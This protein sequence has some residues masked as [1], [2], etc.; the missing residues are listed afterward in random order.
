MAIE[1]LGDIADV[2]VSKAVSPS[3]KTW[4]T[5][6]DW[7]SAVSESGVAHEA[8]PNTAHSDASTVQMGYSY[9]NPPAAADLELLLPLD[10]SAGSTAY[11]ASGNNRDGDITG[12]NVVGQSGDLGTGGHDYSFGEVTLTGEGSALSGYSELTVAALINPD[13][14]PNGNFQ[15]IVAHD[16]ASTNNDQAYQLLVD[17]GTANVGW[18]VNTGGFHGSLSF[19]S[20]SANTWHLVGGTYDGSQVTGYRDGTSV[21]IGSTSGNISDNQDDPQVGSQPGSTRN[22]DGVVGIVWVWSTALTDQQMQSLYDVYN[23]QSTL[24]TATKSFASPVKPDLQNLSYSLN[25]Q[26]I[27]LDVIGSPGTASEEVVTQSLGGASSY[28]LSWS[29]SHTDFRVK[30]KLSTTDPTQTPTVS[31]VELA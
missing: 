25:G 17:D 21:N 20:I 28:S 9:S 13:N 5:A 11:D 4:E 1:S 10:E 18:R 8:V 16:G 7:D 2:S 3:S 12:T 14:V 31:R 19:A 27:D 24:T 6:S 30:I 15:R 26:S 23:S 22:F 29:N